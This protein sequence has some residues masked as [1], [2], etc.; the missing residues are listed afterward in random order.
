[1]KKKESIVSVGGF[2][3]NFTIIPSTIRRATI[4]KFSFLFYCKNPHFSALQFDVCLLIENFFL[5][6]DYYQSLDDIIRICLDK[7]VII[8]LIAKRHRWEG[9]R[10]VFL[11]ILEMQ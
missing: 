8:M 3:H 9:T 6:R 11:R 10:K 4:G 1:M 7:I 2:T 5:F